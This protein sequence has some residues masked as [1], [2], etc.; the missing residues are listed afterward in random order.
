MQKQYF[1]VWLLL[2]SQFFFGQQMPIDFSPTLDNFTVFSGSQ[3][4][5]VADPLD[6]NNM[7]GKFTKTGGSQW[8]GA[9]IDLSAS[10][11][12]DSGKIL[13]LRFYDPN[14]LSH[15]MVLKLENGVN[16]N[17]EVLKNFSSSG[18]TTVSFDFSAAKYSSN[19]A[20]VNASGTYSR[21]TLFIDGGQTSIG[22]YYIDDISDGTTNNG[23]DVVYSQLVWQDEFND[24]GTFSSA[25]WFAETVPPNNGSWSNGELQHYTN[26][27]V[28]VNENNGTLKITA[29]K[30]SYTAYGTQKNYTSARL[31]SLFS[32]TY[33]RVDVRAKLPVG[34]GTWPAIWMLGTSM[35]NSYTPATLNWPNCGEVDIME[36]WGNNPNYIHGSIHTPSSY[37]STVNTS[38]V[39]STDVS[40]TFHVYSMNWSP[41][42]IS[43]M[44][45]NEIYYTYNPTVKNASTWPFFA[46]Q[47][48]LLN[49]AMGGIGGAIDSNFTQSTMEV[50]YVRVYQAALTADSFIQE[51]VKIYP[52]PVSNMLSISVPTENIG[53]KASVFSI[54][55]TEVASFNITNEKTTFDTSALAPGIYFLRINNHQL[56]IV[57]E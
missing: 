55:G 56:K 33:G 37:G 10:I 52:N 17:V 20:P 5:R 26:R 12:L 6:A 48:I 50:D 3:F 25:N 57:K 11:N 18:W 21:L 9:F 32:F 46:P 47:F 43:F 16:P 4:S 38:V 30:E 45:D 51:T 42:K 13:T 22:T 29:K 40:T 44:I 24:S 14:A 19:S 31:N 35:G 54:I 8:E 2:I 41:N 36:H 15:N 49:V 23:L 27:L 34:N 1:L 39:L 53:A 7:V 28:N